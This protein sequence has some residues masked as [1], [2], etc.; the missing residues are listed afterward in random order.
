MPF[1]RSPNRRQ[2]TAQP[3]WRKS[4]G[5]RRSILFILLCCRVK[6][7]RGLFFEFLFF[8]SSLFTD[9]NTLGSDELLTEK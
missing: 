8:L 3:P 6:G 1:H 5:V 2:H 9:R 4:A 7:S